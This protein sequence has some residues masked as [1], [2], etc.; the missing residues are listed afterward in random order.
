MPSKEGPVGTPQEWLRRAKSNLAR[1]KQ[2]KP[3]EAV[4][5]D[6]CFDAQQ[7]AE[8]ALKAVL[9]FCSIDF[10]RT[11][12]IRVLLSLLAPSGQFIPCGPR[13]LGR[14]CLPAVCDEDHK[15]IWLCRQIYIE[16]VSKQQSIAY[17][18]H[19]GRCMGL[20]CIPRGACP[21]STLTIMLTSLT[22]ALGFLALSLGLWVLRTPAA[23]GLRP[24]YS[25]KP[26]RQKTTA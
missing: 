14:R 12:N 25:R 8:K 23:S 19:R 2:P 10:P 18:A 26:A 5:E 24:S 21:M 15:T 3:D 6:L 20:R 22:A 17:I 16:R 9:I 1:A 7:A 4:W 13:C 11:H